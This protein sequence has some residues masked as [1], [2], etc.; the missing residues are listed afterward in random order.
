MPNHE[1]RGTNGAPSARRL[2]AAI[3][4]VRARV[5]PDQIILFGSAAREEMTESSDLDLLV[6]KNR[7]PH[8]PAEAHEHWQ[9][10]ETDDEL[11]VILMDRA[12]AERGRRS[13]AY[14]Q[15]AALEEGQT[16]YAREGV[17]PIRTG[18]VCT[19]NGEEM[20][21]TTLYEPDHANEFLDQSERKW[22]FANYGQH[23]VDECEMLQ[24]SM[25]RA[26]KALT[27]AQGRRV[28]HSHDL[29]A[30]W[31]EAEAQGERIDATRD[32]EELRKLSKYAGE[33]QYA[34]QDEVDPAA[35]WT[36]TKGTAEDLLH[37]AR[38][39]VPQLIQKT[40]ARLKATTGNVPRAGAEGDETSPKP[41][42]G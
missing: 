10:R 40:E 14:I 34:I 20:V 31:E 35:T 41:S 6:I 9:C 42:S 28:R 22:D 12:T 18:P 24:A 30:L 26:L 17:T 15:A 1:H 36:A 5:E 2:Q 23:P 25:E 3:D 37:H 8:E 13:A 19:W 11:D 32:P 16:I 38:R 39:R 21:K 7:E 29:N 27:A 4:V 33:W